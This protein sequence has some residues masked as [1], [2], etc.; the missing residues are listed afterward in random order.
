MSN[1]LARAI[2]AMKAEGASIV[3]G[4]ATAVNTVAVEGAAT[5]VELPALSPVAAG[6]YVAVLQQGADRL[7]L[8]P[9]GSTAW[10][11]W[12]PAVTQSGAVAVTNFR[13]RVTRDARRKI[14]FVTSLNVTGTGTAGQPITVTLPVPAATSGIPIG[15]AVLFDNSTSTFYPAI[16]WL[17]S[18]TTVSMFNATTS[19]SAQILGQAIFTAALASADTIQ[20]S[21]SYEAAS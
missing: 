8:G 11:T 19:A 2:L 5:P 13:S 17:Q 15:Q 21:G 18:T 20:I 9:V 12:T 3:Y 4:E 10:P 6:Q 16:A 14:D 7:I 1:E